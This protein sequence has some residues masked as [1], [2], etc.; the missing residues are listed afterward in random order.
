MNNKLEFDA[1]LISA[2]GGGGFAEV[3]FDVKKYLEAKE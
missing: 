1:P 3:P 2:G